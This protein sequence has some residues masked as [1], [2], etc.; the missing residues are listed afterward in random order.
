MNNEMGKASWWCRR[1]ILFEVYG[2]V[3]D[4]AAHTFVSM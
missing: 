1:A 2:E 4:I 3:E